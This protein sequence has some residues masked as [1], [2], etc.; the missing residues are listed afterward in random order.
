MP[1]NIFF[2]MKCCLDFLFETSLSILD[3]VSHKTEA[4]GAARIEYSTGLGQS[5]LSGPFQF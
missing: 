1:S 3:E 2:L 5:P 4:P